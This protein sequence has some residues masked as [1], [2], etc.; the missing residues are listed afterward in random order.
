MSGSINM[1]MRA[2]DLPKTKKTMPARIATA[3]KPFL[4]PPLPLKTGISQS[5]NGLTSERLTN[6]NRFVSSVCS[7]C[8]GGSVAGTAELKT[9]LRAAEVLWFGA[10]S[11]ARLEFIFHYHA[12]RCS[13][14][15]SINHDG[16]HRL[17]L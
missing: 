1:Q 5:K 11:I 4:N 17:V 13:A 2:R 9:E 10:P 16:A 8:I 12:E 14:L 3:R 7:Q 15:R 6:R